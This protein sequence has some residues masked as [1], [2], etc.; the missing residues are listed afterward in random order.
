M[1]RGNIHTRKP[2]GILGKQIVLDKSDITRA[3][4]QGMRSDVLNIAPGAKQQE[5]KNS[6][7]TNT[8]Y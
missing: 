6:N 4:G 1:L 3:M 5:P 7:H 2:W 8:W